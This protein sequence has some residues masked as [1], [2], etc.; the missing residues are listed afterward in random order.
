MSM[1]VKENKFERDN[2][3]YLAA[4]FFNEEQKD[5]LKSIENL[6]DVNHRNFFSP[7]LEC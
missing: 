4:P 2:F 5:V 3:I 7:R 1:K 6:C